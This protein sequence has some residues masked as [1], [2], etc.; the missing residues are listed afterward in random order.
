MRNYPAYSHAKLLASIS[1]IDWKWLLNELF[2]PLQYTVDENQLIAIDN[3]E[4]LR[5]RCGLHD[6]YLHDNDGIRW[7][8]VYPRLNAIRA[9][10]NLSD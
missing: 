6:L 10:I 8:T 2:K 5:L 3:K 4:D 7:V 1:Q 9:R